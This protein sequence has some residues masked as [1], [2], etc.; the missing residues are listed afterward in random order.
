MASLIEKIIFES[1]PTSTKKIGMNSKRIVSFFMVSKKHFSEF[2]SQTKKSME[3][4]IYLRLTL[5]VLE[6]DQNRK[7]VQLAPSPL[8]I[9]YD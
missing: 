7:M 9:K 4:S 3:G 8:K 5:V 2:S 1:T 6:G